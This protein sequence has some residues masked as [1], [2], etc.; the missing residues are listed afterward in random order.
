MKRPM[1]SFMLIPAPCTGAEPGTGRHFGLK[2]FG[3]LFGTMNG[4]MLFGNGIAP[5]PANH[6]YDMTGSYDIVLWAQ[7]PAYLGTAL[8]FLLLG[9]YP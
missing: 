8:L 1:A 5:V 3:I 6:V 7:V 9:P 2:S 4:L